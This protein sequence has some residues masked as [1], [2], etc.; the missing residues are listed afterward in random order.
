MNSTPR[1]AYF[2]M[3]VALRPEV[4]LVRLEDYDMAIGRL[5]TSG[6][7]VWLNTSAPLLKASSTSGMKAALNGVPSLSVLEATG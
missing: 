4:K 5:L 7:D 3:K 6:V 1:I 2:S